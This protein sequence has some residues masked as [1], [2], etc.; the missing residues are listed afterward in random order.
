[1]H[2]SEKTF[3]DSLAGKPKE[4]APEELTEILPA[5]S[6]PQCAAPALLPSV[7][8]AIMEELADLRREGNI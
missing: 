2:L 7:A 1:M 4:A 5:L 6:L 3:L 8:D